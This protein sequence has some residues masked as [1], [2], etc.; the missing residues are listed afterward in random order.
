MILRTF[1]GIG[2]GS[3]LATMAA[4]VAEYAPRR[5]Q[6]F[7]VALLYGGY[8]LGAI[9]TGLI[10]V[11]TIPTFGWK[12]TLVG[13]GC[14]AAIML[15]VLYVLLPESMQFLIKRRP[16]N[17]L[18]K[19]NR[20]LAR[21]QRAQVVVLPNASEAPSATGVAG[22]FARGRAKGTVLL[23]SSMVFGFAT[24]WFAISWIPKLAALSG[25][26]QARAIYAGTSF[27]AGAFA[28]TVAL[29][30]ITARIRLQP[31]IAVFLTA[32]AVVMII[33][34]AAHLSAGAIITLAF[35]IGFLLQGGFN[36][37]YPL[38]TQLYPAEI[39]STGIGWTMGVGRIGA[40]L[41]PFVGGILIAREVPVSIIFLIFAVPA[42]LGGL[43]AALVAT[44][45]SASKDSSSST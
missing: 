23:W 41:G 25:L 13:A 4:L 28:G 44:G 36:G 37:I 45:T 33:F 10:A 7:A 38:G 30:L 12:A 39:R 21:M 26:D 40:V 9:A 1:V 32:A 27:N 34:G 24:L 17:A 15:P 42:V 6:N 43:C 19:L 5:Q 18:E 22:L 14:V 29:G 2:I 3:V 31:M 16:L 35:C 8:P 11:H 20:I